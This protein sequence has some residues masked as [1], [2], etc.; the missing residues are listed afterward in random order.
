LDFWDYVTFGALF[1]VLAFIVA[2]ILWLAATNQIEQL[3][4]NDRTEALRI[5]KLKY[6][7]GSIDLL[8]VL[9]LQNAEIASQRE[10]IKLR[11]EQLAN[12]ITLHLALGGSFD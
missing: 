12:L 7:A 11:Y 8:S 3:V 4:L 2:T 9:Q 5:A 10:L 6:E 1:L